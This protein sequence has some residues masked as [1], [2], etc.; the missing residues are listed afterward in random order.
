VLEAI[1]RR[2]ALAATSV[3][4]GKTLKVSGLCEDLFVA[5]SPLR[6][7]A[8]LRHIIEFCWARAAEGSTTLLSTWCS[9][10]LQQELDRIRESK[11]VFCR[12]QSGFPTPAVAFR[13]TCDLLDTSSAQIRRAIEEYSENPRNGCLHTVGTFLDAT[14]SVLVMY[15]RSNGCTIFELYVPV[16]K[17]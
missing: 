7:V 4:D 2:F 5:V 15:Q 13:V 1:R 17:G 8:A 10:R 9:D 3:N 6:L 11:L 16:G 12:S 14:R